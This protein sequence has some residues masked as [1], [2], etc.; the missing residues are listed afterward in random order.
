MDSCIGSIALCGDNFVYTAATYTSIK[1]F[2]KINTDLFVRALRASVP[3]CWMRTHSVQT[4]I[5]FI[6]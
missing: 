6:K 1:G 4:V 2:H 5:K 3:N